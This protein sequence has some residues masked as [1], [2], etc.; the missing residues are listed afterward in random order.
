[1]LIIDVKKL[2]SIE[3][4]LKTLKKKFDQTGTLRELRERKEFKK[5]SVKHREVQLKAKYRQSFKNDN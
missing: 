5:P 1:M 3:R 4:A 2:G